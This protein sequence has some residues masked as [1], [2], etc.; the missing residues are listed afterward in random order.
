MS[1][2]RNNAQRGLGTSAVQAQVSLS[3]SRSPPPQTSQS[4]TRYVSA[5]P[6]SASEKHAVRHRSFYRSPSPD[7]RRRPKRQRLSAPK[8]SIGEKIATRSAKQHLDWQFFEF[9]LVRRLLPLKMIRVHPLHAAYDL[10]TSFECMKGISISDV[11]LCAAA[12]L[13]GK[14]LKCRLK[15]HRSEIRPRKFQRI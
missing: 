2:A 1:Q 12:G 11:Q 15:E 5:R 13:T 7:F 6:P 14:F 3:V 9:V 10:E 4:R 8:R